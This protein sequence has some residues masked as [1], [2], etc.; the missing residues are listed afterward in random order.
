MITE[1]KLS[2]VDLLANQELEND[3]ME[4]LVNG[5]AF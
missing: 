4:D 2:L 5:N 3:F 1:N